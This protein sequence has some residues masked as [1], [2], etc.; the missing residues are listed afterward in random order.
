MGFAMS[1]I[2]GVLPVVANTESDPNCHRISLIISYHMIMNNLGK[3]KLVDWCGNQ[4]TDWRIC[5]ES[6]LSAWVV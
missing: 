2:C 1:E 4:A 6:K 5:I 3:I